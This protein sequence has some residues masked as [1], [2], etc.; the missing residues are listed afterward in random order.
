MMKPY[1]FSFNATM[2]TRQQVLDFLDTLPQ[3]LNWYAPLPESVIII[4]ERGVSE[5][6]ALIHNRYPMSYFIITEIPP[7]GNDG[8]LPKVAWD[9]INNPRSSGRWR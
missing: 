4:S 3:V 8:W 7:G 1:L 9:F 5:L 2:G 6:Q